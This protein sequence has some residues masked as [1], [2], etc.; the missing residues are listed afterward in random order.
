VLRED[1]GE[2]NTS[3][4]RTVVNTRQGERQKRTLD[5]RSPGSH[6]QVE[7]NPRQRR[8]GEQ[9]E[10]GRGGGEAPTDEQSRFMVIDETGGDLEGEQ[11]LEGSGERDR[12]REREE[13]EREERAAE[14]ERERERG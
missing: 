2:Q 1:S 7:R 13:R 11:D 14:E 10:R 5:E 6:G 3:T 8:N 9:E 4:P 12:E